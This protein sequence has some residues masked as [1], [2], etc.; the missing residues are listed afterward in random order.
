MAS[1]RAAHSV[2]EGEGTAESAPKDVV[3]ALQTGGPPTGTPAGKTISQEV[4]KRKHSYLDHAKTL[5][6]IYDAAGA[7]SS[8]CFPL[9]YPLLDRLAPRLM[10]SEALLILEKKQI[11]KY[12]AA[13][14]A[15]TAPSP[16]SGGSSSGD[17]SAGNSSYCLVSHSHLRAGVAKRKPREVSEAFTYNEAAFKE[18]QQQALQRQHTEEHEGIGV[19]GMEQQQ[20][21]QP[22]KAA[23]QNRFV[24]LPRFCSC[25]FYRDRVLELGDAFTCPHELAALLLHLLDP[26]GSLTQQLEAS[27]YNA[28]LQQHLD[29]VWRSWI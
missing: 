16:L 5:Q 8:E 29:A 14:P 6:A 3:A 10:L 1:W 15:A 28:L 11:Q 27:A 17:R 23:P 13:P 26:S 22:A 25:P 4:A 12:A 2:I 20:Q 19:E 24:V 7:G 9:F 21:H 18:Q